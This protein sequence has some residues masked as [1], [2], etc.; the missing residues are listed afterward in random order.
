MLH[1]GQ[2]RAGSCERES[3]D[4]RVLGVEDLSSSLLLQAGC[5]H[6]QEHRRSFS[7]AVTVE[8]STSRVPSRARTLTSFGEAVTVEPSTPRAT[9]QWMNVALCVILIYVVI[10]F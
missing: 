9:L 6:G 3:E 2:Q 7:E 5:R 1:T 10:R 4:D 8:P